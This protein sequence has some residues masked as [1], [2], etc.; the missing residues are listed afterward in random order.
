MIS[1]S[2]TA[3]SLSIVKLRQLVEPATLLAEALSEAGGDDGGGLG[4]KLA[5]LMAAVVVLGGAEVSI[6]P[7]RLASR[8]V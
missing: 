7:F 8:R 3:T 5:D 2:F 4:V 1:Q 6:T